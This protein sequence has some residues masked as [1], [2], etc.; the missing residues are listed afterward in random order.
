[1]ESHKLLWEVRSDNLNKFAHRRHFK[2]A[3]TY[4]SLGSL[5]LAEHKFDEARGYFK[6]VLDINTELLGAKVRI[7]SQ[8][9]QKKTPPTWI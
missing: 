2:T 1:M 3:E 6:L 8:K 5:C 9:E 4:N 7:E